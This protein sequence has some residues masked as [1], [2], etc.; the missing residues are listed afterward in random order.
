MDTIG[1]FLL[2]AIVDDNTGIG[3]GPVR[4]DVLDILVV[5]E[6]NSVGASCASFVVSLGQGAEFFPE[7][8][9]PIVPEKGV[10]SEFFILTNGFSGSGVDDWVSEMFEMW[11]GSRLYPFGEKEIGSGRGGSMAGE[12]MEGILGDEVRDLDVD[13]WVFVYC[14]GRYGDDDPVIVFVSEG[15]SRRG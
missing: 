15:R 11:Y 1:V 12:S 13:R 8:G 9:C 7:S 6:E 14:Y 2:W 5:Q 3:N 10:I 4:G